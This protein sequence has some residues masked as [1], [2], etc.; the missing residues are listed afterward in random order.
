LPKSVKNKNKINHKIKGNKLGI[1]SD[2]VFF[3]LK[4]G[5]PISDFYKV[6][7]DEC[8]LIMSKFYEEKKIYLG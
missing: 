4:N 8:T 7:K 1:N 3:Y 6:P 2:K 5:F